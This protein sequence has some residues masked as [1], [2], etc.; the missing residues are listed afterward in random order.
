MLCSMIEHV[1]AGHKKGHTPRQVLANE[2][3]A[4]IAQ[5]AT[6][7]PCCGARRQLIETEL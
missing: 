4:M 6:H 1:Y 7:Q 5:N 3:A 2:V